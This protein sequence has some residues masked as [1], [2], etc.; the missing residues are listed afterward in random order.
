MR[1]SIS[2]SATMVSVVS[3][4]NDSKKVCDPTGAPRTRRPSLVNGI[5]EGVAGSGGIDVGSPKA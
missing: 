3:E 1:A 5:L 2:K 4:L